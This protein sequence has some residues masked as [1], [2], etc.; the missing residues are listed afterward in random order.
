MVDYTEDG[1]LAPMLSA[2]TPTVGTVKPGLRSSARNG[3]HPSAIG[4]FQ[5]LRRDCP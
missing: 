2:S 5:C 3:E 4:A 1:V